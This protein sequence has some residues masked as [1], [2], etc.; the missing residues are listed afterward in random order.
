MTAAILGLL[1][2]GLSLGEEKVVGV[3]RRQHSISSTK[4]RPFIRVHDLSIGGDE[5]EAVS[6]TVR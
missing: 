6:L 3:T 1:R 4:V 5:A 2:K